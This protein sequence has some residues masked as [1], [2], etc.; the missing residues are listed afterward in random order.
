[1]LV[2]NLVNGAGASVRLGESGRKFG[3]NIQV[4]AA[5][6]AGNI[7]DIVTSNSSHAWIPRLTNADAASLLQLPPAVQVRWDGSR[8][9]VFNLGEAKEVS[10][11]TVHAAIERTLHHAEEQWSARQN[12]E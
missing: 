1:M 11:D 9:Y 3:G 5:S 2:Q 12:G 4:V 6:L 8:E 10:V 7:E